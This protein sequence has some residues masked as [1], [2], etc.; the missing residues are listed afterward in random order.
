MADA[1]CATLITM[2]SN[3]AATRRSICQTIS[4]LPPTSSSGLGRVSES[5]RMRSPR[6]AARIIA[7]LM[8]SP[9][10][11]L[12]AASP[13]GGERLGAARRRSS[14]GVAD[15]RATA[16]EFV[17]QLEHRTEPVVARA[18]TAQIR[19]YARHFLQ[20][21]GLAVAMPQSRED[22][23]HLQLALHAHPFEVAPE[24]A[25]VGIDRHTGGARTFPIAHR[26]IDLAFIIPR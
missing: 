22:T 24:R 4:A 23:E 3:P 10:A 12:C 17:E 5:G 25:E 8:D 18:G 14:E 1:R 13:S 15:R 9:E 21:R 20:V 26:P 16:F 11:A 2:R 6:P 7:A 19:H